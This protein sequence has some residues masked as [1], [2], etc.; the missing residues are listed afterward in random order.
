MAIHSCILTWRIPRTEETPQMTLTKATMAP[1]QTSTDT[2]AALARFSI[3]IFASEAVFN[4]TITC[5]Y[6]L[7]LFFI[8]LFRCIGS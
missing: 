8:Y 2:Q 4:V 5:C 1:A 3:A 6:I 7:S